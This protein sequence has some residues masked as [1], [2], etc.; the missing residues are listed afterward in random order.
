MR[1]LSKN[2][3]RKVIA[4]WE[5]LR[6]SRTSS[7]LASSSS[8][9]TPPTKPIW[10]RKTSKLAKQLNSCNIKIWR[11]R[12]E[13]E[14]TGCSY[15]SRRIRRGIAQRS[16][17]SSWRTST[18]STKSLCGSSRTWSLRRSVSRAGS[19]SATN[20]FRKCWI[21]S[22]SYSKR[23][24]KFTTITVKLEQTWLTRSSHDTMAMTT[25][26]WETASWNKQSIRLSRNSI[27][28]IWPSSRLRK[29]S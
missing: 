12:S 24:M 25:T 10:F 2:P 26:K 17:W 28:S 16:T 29:H 21:R 1:Q 9:R 22:R 3:Y 6:S 20:S 11:C 18:I 8:K 4:I 15:W 5:T 14:R 19:S 7:A 13:K 23:Q 27:S